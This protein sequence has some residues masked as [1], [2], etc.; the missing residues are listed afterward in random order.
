MHP[1]HQTQRLKISKPE[2]KETTQ[3]F[4]RSG[5]NFLALYLTPAPPLPLTVMHHQKST[6]FF[7]PSPQKTGCLFIRKCNSCHYHCITLYHLTA[8][9]LEVGPEA[10]QEKK[11]KK[12]IKKGSGWKCKIRYKT[13]IP[14]IP[15]AGRL[16]RP[17][18][19]YDSRLV[20]L[21]AKSDAVAAVELA[22]RPLNDREKKS[23]GELKRHWNEKR[24]Q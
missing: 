13:A 1:N 20:W 22:E 10:G 6:H 15:D 9:S 21:P 18:P 2:L 5:G 19:G 7:K 23:R 8:L 17:R 4:H 3:G 14:S 12:K 24:W 16:M 11:K